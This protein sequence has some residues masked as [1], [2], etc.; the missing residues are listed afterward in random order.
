MDINDN[1]NKHIINL[2]NK[3]NFIKDW[4]SYKYKEKPL[5]I[6]GP[7]GIGKTTLANYILKDW[8]KV[9]IRSD[10]CKS[11]IHFDDY[12]ND[13]LY[14]KS[15][16]MMFNNKVYKAL[17][18]DDLNYIQNNDKKLFKS[19]M[20]FSKKKKINHPIIYIFNSINKNIKFLLSRCFPFKI[21]FSE[22]DLVEITKEYFLKDISIPTKNIKELVNKSNRNLHNIIVN[23]QFY[24]NNF[25]DIHIYDNINEE[26]SEHIR[27]VL[28]MDNY[29]DIYNHCYSDYMVIG[30]NILESFYIWL[31]NINLLSEK[32]KLFIMNKIYK[33]NMIADILYRRDHD[34]NGW[35]LINHI[36][37][38][39]T[40]FP[41][42]IIKKYNINITTIPYTKYISKSIIY[43][44]KNKILSNN[45]I[46]RLQLLYEM[47]D[48]YYKNDTKENQLLFN[49]KKYISFYD[50]PE[51]LCEHFLKYFKKY[52]KEKIKIFY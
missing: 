22:I 9:Y 34:I 1:L 29:I 2:F 28:S 17:L 4:L 37:T 5:A 10:L 16:T 50:I 19:I 46:E 31:N 7:P 39:N 27:K 26:L 24:R 25:K 13:S 11:S 20:L 52:P 36:I 14:K 8:I 21:D 38:Y 41:I 12:L 3:D 15:I 42:Y 40:L 32:D 44:S 47:L 33:D 49:I 35:N 23:I 43:T 18:I 51:N 30:L 48:L 45:C 6:Y